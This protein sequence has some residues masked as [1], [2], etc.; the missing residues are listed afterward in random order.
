M[1]VK[2]NLMSLKK[3]GA[4][5]KRSVV[6]QC[7]V[8]HLQFHPVAADDRPIFAPVELERFARLKGQR[9]KRAASASEFF[10]LPIG[11]PRASKGGNATI[12]ALIAKGSQIRMQLFERAFLLAWLTRF[13]RA[14]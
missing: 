13:C 3:I 14:N 10:A 5:K 2:Q 6:R 7:E 11:F 8:R 9:N 12:G 4:Q 1:G